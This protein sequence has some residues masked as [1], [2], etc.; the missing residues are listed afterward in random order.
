M[1]SLHRAAAP[2]DAIRSLA[3]ILPARCRIDF[4]RLGCTGC[5]TYGIAAADTEFS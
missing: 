1:G 4:F 5:S 2:V 3:K